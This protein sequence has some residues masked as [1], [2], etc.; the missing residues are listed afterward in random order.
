MTPI[1]VMRA[2]GVP[3]NS[4]PWDGGRRVP[5]TF[6]RALLP[7]AL[8]PGRRA[9]LPRRHGAP[10][11]EEGPGGQDSRSL[12]WRRCPRCP[13][14]LRDSA[15]V[16]PGWPRGWR[17]WW[18]RV[19]LQPPWPWGPAWDHRAGEGS[20]L[21]AGEGAGGAFSGG[22]AEGLQTSHRPYPGSRALCW[23]RGWPVPWV[24]VE[25]YGQC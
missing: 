6:S 18:V 16:S 2:G 13:R 20:P 15:A 1:S 17:P 21:R 22:G 14:C 5:G 12:C 10:S 7:L 25:P 19:Q 4:C 23:G 24:G 8:W 9:D 3:P 11:G